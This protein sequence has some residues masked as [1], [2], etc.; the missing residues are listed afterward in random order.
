MIQDLSST[1]RAH[2]EITFFLV[3]GIGY[4]LGKLKVGSFS[5]GAVTG[6]LLAGVAV[7]QLGVHL[8]GEVRQCFFLLFLFSIGFRSGPQFFR[9]LKRDGLQQ[10]A[11]AAIVATTGLVVAYLVSRLFSYD[12]GTAAGVIAGSLTESATIGT[13]SDAISRLGLSAVD[14]AAMINRIP[15]AFAVTY[16]IGVV[17]AAWFLAQLAPRLMG[18]DLEEEC[19]RFERELQ[20]GHEKE[21]T[22][23]RDIEFRAYTVQPGSPLVG[24]RVHEIEQQKSCAPFVERIRRGDQILETDETTTVLSG[25]TLATTGRRELLIAKVDQQ[26]LGYAKWTTRSFSPPRRCWM[27]W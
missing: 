3:L 8:S 9:G 10:A 7:G 6:T 2:P 17:G 16:L 12:A 26:T 13:A 25:D 5:L 24:R 20:G 11:L 22:A 4:A 15:V 18:I 23:R 1:L 14:Q 27:W 21:S 19:R